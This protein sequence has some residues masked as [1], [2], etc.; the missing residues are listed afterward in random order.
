MNRSINGFDYL[1]VLTTFFVVVIHTAASYVVL[2]TTL[3][4]S[5]WMAAN[6]F[7]GLSRWSVPVFFMLSG[8]F[9]LDPKRV[10]PL[11]FFYKKRV[12]KL[13]I[14]LLFWSLIYFVYKTLTLQVPL[15]A[16]DFLIQLYTNDI[17]YH[18]WFLYTLIGIYMLLPILRYCVK[19]LP[20]SYFLYGAI[21]WFIAVPIIKTLNEV[22]GYTM[23]FEIPFA[24]YLG[25][26]ILGYYLRVH[27]FSKFATYTLYVTGLVSAIITIYGTYLG[28]ANQNGQFYPFFYSNFSPTTALIA[29]A[30]FLAFKSLATN[31]MASSVQW[32]SNLSFRVYLIH[33]LVLDLFN[34]NVTL[35]DDITLFVKIPIVAFSVFI[36]SLC[37][38]FIIS[39][40]PFF[41]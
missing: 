3:P 31:V 27:T 2:F 35:F 4:T 34:K 33:A 1:R 29:I 41:K 28:T 30:L 9:L 39:K 8:A 5:E 25:Y 22:L 14:P 11:R 15:T 17:F 18:L 26:F 24:G 21:I 37:I 6:V 16:K 19:D 12:M 38:S 32:M 36:I 20:A 13:L 23:Y 7:N 10:E 40:I